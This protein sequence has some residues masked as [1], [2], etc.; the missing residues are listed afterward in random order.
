MPSMQ[1]SQNHD[2]KNADSASLTMRA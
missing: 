1:K 2:S